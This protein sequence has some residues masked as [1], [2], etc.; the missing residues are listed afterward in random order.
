MA[1]GEGW[2]GKFT[3]F[4]TG[5]EQE[6]GETRAY[7]PL[8]E[9][10]GTSKTPSASFNFERGKFMCFS[11]CGGFAISQVFEMMRDGHTPDKRVADQPRDELA[12]RRRK[13]RAKAEGTQAALPSEDQI[14]EWHERLVGKRDLVQE[15]LTKRGLQRRTLARYKVGYDGERI[16]IPVYDGTGEL[17]NIR[18][19]GMGL[20][21]NK[22]LNWPGYGDAT[23]YGLDALKM[24]KVVLVE[25]EMDKL[26]GRQNRFPTLSAT[27]GAGTWLPEWNGLFIGKQ[28]YICYDLD[29]QGEQG[30]RKV[31]NQLRNVAEQVFIVKWPMTATGSDMT[32]Y[33]VHQGYGRQ[34]FIDLLRSTPPFRERKVSRNRAIAEVPTLRMR[35]SFSPAHLDKPIAMVATVSGRAATPSALPRTVQ[36]NCGQD[37]QKTKCANCPMELRWGGEHKAEIPADDLLVLRMLDT[38]EDKRRAELLAAQEI[39]R[40]C[41]KVEVT[42]HAQWRVDE[43]A[44]VP[45]VDDPSEGEGEHV[46]RRVFNVTEEGS[47][48]PVNTTARLTGVSTASP[49]DG[50][51]VFQSWAFEETKT[52]LDR[53][54]MTDDLLEA[55]DEAF[56]PALDQTPMGKLHEIARDLA[57]NVTH[58]YGRPELHIAYD[59]VW[60]SVLDFS[61]RGNRIGKGWLELLVMGDT[62]TGKSEAAERLRHH[63]QCGVLKS[64]EGATLAGL[65]GGAQQVGNNW[66]ITWGTIPLQDRRLVILDE[67]SG[68]SDKNII[69]QMSAV[70]SS[71]KAQVSKIVSQETFARTRTIWIS[72]PPDG[73]PIQQTNNGAIDAIQKLIVNPEDVARFD[74]ALVAAQEDVA[75]RLIN[76]AVPPRAP[77]VATREL[78][79]AL[80]TW[81]WSRRPDQVHWGKGVERAVLAAAEDLGGRYIADPP[82]VQPENVRVKLARLSVA[83]A[84]R[85]FSHDGTGECVV[86]LKEHVKAAVQLLDML[87]GKRW[88]GYADHSKKELRAKQN[89]HEFSEQCRSFLVAHEGVLDTLYTVIND[90]QFRARDFE[91]FGGMDKDMAQQAVGELLKMGMVRRRSKGYINMMPELI[92][93]VRELESD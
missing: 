57:A 12:D 46:L 21:A 84:A 90:T 79:S 66:V 20:K 74:F 59:L 1:R 81:A 27:A 42:T 53:F 13:R 71:G 61:F 91:E 24:K 32:D 41:P 77:H 19:Y 25:G 40:T 93:L 65:V 55:L 64:C 9:N 69:E 33:F 43:L 58:I 73:R 15:I 7:C 76:S 31:A 44:V 78:S 75:S 2:R 63:Y 92:R 34:N 49:R 28:V 72:N 29:T 14:T 35:E 83:I 80:V 5:Q 48:T 45:N 30:A 56:A 60:H 51:V 23:L 50:H 89:A 82:L 17:V 37:W 86:V 38:A 11:R 26:L 4:L 8:H 85:L 62:R 54:Q 67:V 22:M 3:D 70:R 36:L 6:D 52:S 39:P 88:F 18:R 47:L 10:P 68:I 16:T 87:Y